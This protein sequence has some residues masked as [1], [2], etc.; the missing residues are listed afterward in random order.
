MVARERRLLEIG[1]EC[2]PTGVKVTRRIFMIYSAARSPYET[3]PTCVCGG[4]E[5]EL[6]D[7]K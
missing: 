2:H 5:D 4:N 1:K 6:V 3:G 7:V